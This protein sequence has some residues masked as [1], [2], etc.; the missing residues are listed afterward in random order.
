MKNLAWA[1]QNGVS[2]K[3]VERCLAQYSESYI[4]DRLSQPVKMIQ[5]APCVPILYFAVEQNSPE[6]IRILHHAGAKLG[7]R[8]WLP[9]SSSLGL[10]LLGAL[11]RSATL[12]AERS[13][14]CSDTRF[15]KRH[16]S[17]RPLTE[18]SRLLKPMTAC[19]FSKYPTTYLDKS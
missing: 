15:G 9:D 10:P 5:G 18:R 2:G 17:S 4:A 19:L 6:I 7:H 8:I 16:K 11:L 1:I 12:S 3:C 13:I 14:S